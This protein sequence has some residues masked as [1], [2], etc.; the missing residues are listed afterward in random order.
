MINVRTHLKNSSFYAESTD[1]S[2]KIL[3]INIF[4]I[5][6]NK[7]LQVRKFCIHASCRDTLVLRI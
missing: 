3:F 2:V 4:E 5:G 6:S 7:L 1:F